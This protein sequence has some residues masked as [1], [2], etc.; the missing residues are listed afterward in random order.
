[1]SAGGAI[2]SSRRAPEVDDAERVMLRVASG[3]CTEKEMAAWLRERL[4]A[5]DAE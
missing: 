2:R 4:A 3:E 1:L 5:S